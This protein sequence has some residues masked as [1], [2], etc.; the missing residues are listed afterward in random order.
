[1][2]Q[3]DGGKEKEGEIPTHDD[4]GGRGVDKLVAS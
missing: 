3:N 2:Q 1:M 4:G